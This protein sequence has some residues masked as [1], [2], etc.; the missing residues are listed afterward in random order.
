MVK[1]CGNMD[2]FNARAKRITDT[3]AY[4]MPRLVWRDQPIDELRSMAVVQTLIGN[5]NDW[6]NNINETNGNLFELQVV[7]WDEFTTRDM[8]EVYYLENRI[9]LP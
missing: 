7:S 8:F 9:N 5:Y 4:V 3:Y 6:F 2:E 1:D